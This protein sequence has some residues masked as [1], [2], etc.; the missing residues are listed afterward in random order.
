VIAAI[1][2]IARDRSVIG[3]GFTEVKSVGYLGIR[4]PAMTRGHGDGGDSS[5]GWL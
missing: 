1:A 3:T 5:P 4:S 2:V